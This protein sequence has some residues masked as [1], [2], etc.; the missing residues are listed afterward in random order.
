MQEFDEAC[1]IFDGV[2]FWTNGRIWRST[3]YDLIND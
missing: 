3:N 1:E 2:W